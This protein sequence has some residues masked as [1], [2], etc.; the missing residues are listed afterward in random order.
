MTAGNDRLGPNEALIGTPGSRM[1][2]DT[3]ALCL[4]IDAMERN[5]AAM[6]AFCRDKGVVLRPHA[7]THKSVKIAQRQ[8]ASGAVGACC[9]TMGEAEVMAAG[10]IPGVLVT[11]PQVTPPKIARLIALNLAAENGFAVVV[12]HPQN[13]ADLSQAAHASGKPL[14]VLLDFSCGHH[15]TG[16]ATQDD[17]VALAHAIEA[18]GGLRLTGLQ[19]YYGNL[20]HIGDRAERHERTRRQHAAIAG[21]V[22]KLRAAGFAVPVVTGAGTGTHDIDAGAGVFTELQAGSYVFMDVEYANAL[23]DG[24]NALPFETSLFVQTAVVSIESAKVPGG[25]VTTDAGLKCFATE[26][27]KPEVTAVFGSGAGYGYA[28]AGDEHGRL[29]FTPA[30]PVPALGERI[31]VMTPHCD[32][33]VNLH[34]FYHLVRGDTLVDIWPVD[35]RGKR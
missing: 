9:A 8:I 18:A 25:Y 19:A 15:R 4:D 10:G 33:T 14:D 21:L 6:A 17:A 22:R 11:S 26:G 2:L 1:L 24:R 23:R 32:P 5:I 13:V 31:E 28:Y 27:P 30:Q 34:D 16:A 12:D 35:A 29:F 7:K 3:P 20:Q